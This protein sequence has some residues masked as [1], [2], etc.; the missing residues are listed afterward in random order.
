MDKLDA[1]VHGGPSWLYNAILKLFVS[2]FKGLLPAVL[3]DA[4]NKAVD[5]FDQRTLTKANLV[6][7]IHN[8]GVLDY[9]M[10]SAPIFEN[11]YLDS[12][13]KGEISWLGS[14]KE[15]SFHPKPFPESHDKSRMAY[16]WVSDYVMN[17]AG[18][19]L[20]NQGI[21]QHYLRPSDLKSNDRHYLKTTCMNSYCTGNIIVPLQDNFPNSE[22]HINMSTSIAP[23]LRIVKGKIFGKFQGNMT[24][25]AR[26]PYK[27]VEYLFDTTVAAQVSLNVSVNDQNITAQVTD[28]IPSVRVTDTKVANITGEMLTNIFK[29]VSGLFIIPKLNEVGARGLPLLH[30]KEVALRNPTLNLVENAILLGTDVLWQ[31]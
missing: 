31:P 13:H 17:T 26:L 10:L 18:Y 30:S 25:F 24:Y 2:S 7:N 27:A 3:C 11:G 5:A 20:Q 9:S 16:I 4:A 23:T 1:R 14:H 12:N 28:I 8:T 15:V 19:V 6:L 21:L 22:I 29:I